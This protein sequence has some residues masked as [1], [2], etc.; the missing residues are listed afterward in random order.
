MFDNAK[1]GWLA[2]FRVIPSQFVHKM[3]IHVAQMEQLLRSISADIHTN[4]SFAI[5]GTNLLM[6]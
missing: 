2:V 4:L 6:I 1:S 5:L 3:Q